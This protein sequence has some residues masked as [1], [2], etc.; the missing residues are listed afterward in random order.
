MTHSIKL[1][2]CSSL[3]LCASVVQFLVVSS[4]SADPPSV[5]YIYPAGGQRGTKV[6]VRV[7]G[8]YL[9]DKS[10][11]EM[12]GPGITVSPEIV[13]TKRI[14]FE[15]PLIKQPA[16]QG[17]EDYPQDYLGQVQIAADAP[18]GGHSC[19]TWNAQGV[20]P[21]LRFVVGTLPEVVEQE[22]DGQPIPTKVSLPTTINGRIFPREDVDVWTFDAVAGQ[23]ITCS[24]EAANLGLLNDPQLPR[25]EAQIEVRDPQGRV[26]PVSANSVRTD[27]ELRFTAAEAGVYQVRIW[28]SKFS[29]LQHYV[30]RLTV[31]AGPWV[32]S[33]YPLGGKRGSEM[34]VETVGQGIAGN[35]LK[36]RWPDVEP[37]IVRHSF[38]TSGQ[39]LNAIAC[40]V[41]NLPEVIEPASGDFPPLAVPGVANGRIESAGDVDA[42]RFAATKGTA[43]KIEVRA[44]RLGSPLDAVLV[45]KDAQGKELAQADDL[46]GGSPDCEVSFTPPENGQYVAEVRD[47]FASRGGPMFAYRLRIAQPTPDFGLS[48]AVDSLSVVVGGEQKLPVNIDRRGGFN[49][50]VKLAVEGLPAN[51]T[52]A[53]LDV[54]AGQNKG[55]LVIKAVKESPV[56]VAKFSVIGKAMLGDQMAQRQATFVGPADDAPTDQVL[57]ACTL[58]TPFKFKSQYEFRYIAR[59]GTLKKHFVIERNGFAGPLDVLLADK[60][61]RHLQGVTGPT[62]TVPAEASEFDYTVTLPPWMELGRTSR[63]NLM[64]VGEVADAAGKKHKVS[65]STVEQNE[66]LVALVSPGPLRLSVDKSAVRCTPGSELVVPVHLHRQVGLTGPCRLELV[67]PEHMRDISAKPVEVEAGGDQADL[68]LQLGANPGPLN[69]PLLIRGVSEVDGSPITAEVNLELLAKP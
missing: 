56:Q 33:I 47:R 51:V 14:W 2:L 43:L 15:G 63:T 18:L 5:V 24:V 17:K 38:E 29:G 34:E 20:T 6:D 42:W 16:S 19:R 58:A 44:A 8:H 60:Q 50:P 7:G 67:V 66:Q 13:R 61:G 68:K 59:G 57:L 1:L 36:V 48:F 3:C 35:K 53:E 11:W 46:P 9:Y 12:R 39:L 23:S 40:D 32:D 37:S 30:Y 27:P 64:L 62:I 45:I 28:D 49:G 69:M 55:E 25:L 21:G 31:T 65:F 4:A 52:S 54:P 22:T 10:A 26:V 41:D